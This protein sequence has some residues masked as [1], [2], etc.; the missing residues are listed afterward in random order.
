[1]YQSFQQIHGVD[2]IKGIDGV[3]SRTMQLLIATADTSQSCTTFAD[4]KDI[5]MFPN[6]CHIDAEKNMILYNGL[7]DKTCSFVEIA[8]GICQL[9]SGRGFNTNKIEVAST[10]RSAQRIASIIRDVE[11]SSLLIPYPGIWEQ[12]EQQE[13]LLASAVEKEEY[14]S[15]WATATVGIDYKVRILNTLDASLS[16]WNYNAFGD[17][18]RFLIRALANGEPFSVLEYCWKKIKLSDTMREKKRYGQVF[19]SVLVDYMKIRSEY[20]VGP[21]LPEDYN[22]QCAYKIVNAVDSL[23]PML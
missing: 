13:P 22:D 2:V 5:S 21:V 6:Y 4:I 17:V 11:I 12:A 18:N 20:Y 16:E 15:Q 23:K 10:I 8:I 14:F 9:I 1:M 3:D 19:L 7:D